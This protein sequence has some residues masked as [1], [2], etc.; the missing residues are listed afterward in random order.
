[1][2]YVL[3]NK[4]LLKLEELMKNQHIWSSEPPSEQALA[5]TAPF[6]CDTLPFEQWLQFI[7]IP[8]MYQLLAARQP[9]PTAMAIAP[10]A[11]HVWQ[12]NGPHQSIINLLKE[13]DELINESI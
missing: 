7:F 9:M 8:K 13:F 3:F 4:L 1:M 5:S 12:H 2:R 10:M 11:E 6:A